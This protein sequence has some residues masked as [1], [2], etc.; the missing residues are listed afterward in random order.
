MS[1]IPQTKGF[2]FLLHKDPYCTQQAHLLVC[3]CL[4]FHLVSKGKLYLV[5]I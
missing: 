2:Y 5:G 1:G 3:V 4:C